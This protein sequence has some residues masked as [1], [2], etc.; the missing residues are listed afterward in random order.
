MS[1]IRAQQWYN[2]DSP[3]NLSGY[4]NDKSNRMIGWAT[5]R[6][7]RIK[8]QLCLVHIL[9]RTCEYDFNLFNEETNSFEPG[10]INETI[11]IKSN[12]TIDQAFEYKSKDELDTYVYQG[13][14]GSY[15][16]DGYVYEFRGHLSDIQKNLSELHRLGW[17][18]YRTRAVII[19]LTLYNPNVELFIS[20]TL[21]TEFLSTGGIYPQSQFEPMNFYGRFHLFSLINNNTISFSSFHIDLSIDFHYHLYDIH[22][23]FYVHRTSIVLSIEMELFP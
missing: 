8:S 1:N 16:G 6:Q 20:V 3:R 4:I 12:S 21:L 17:I 10:W 22:H 14:Y 13:D 5:M 15:N 9:N 7:L 11:I 18:D 23:L 19:Q 2:G